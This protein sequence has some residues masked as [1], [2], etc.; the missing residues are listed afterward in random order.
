MKNDIEEILLS[1]EQIQ[2]KVK[3]MAAQLSGQ[4]S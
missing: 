4:V 2:A 1:E 3:E